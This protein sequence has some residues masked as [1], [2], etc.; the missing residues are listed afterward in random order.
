MSPTQL[1]MTT[2]GRVCARCARIVRIESPFTMVLAMC[3]SH[4]VP[5]RR[6]QSAPLS[7]R[8]PYVGPGH[9]GPAVD[10]RGPRKKKCDENRP[11]CSD[12]R[13]LNLPCQWFSTTS[14]AETI[15]TS[16]SSSPDSHATVSPSAD[17][18]LPSD[19]DPLALS[20]ITPEDDEEFIATLFP[21][22]LP[23]QT[24]LVL[25]LEW[26]PISTNPFLRG[27]EDRSLFNH[28]IHV[29][30]RALSRS[31]DPDR[32]PFLVTLLPLA[33][34]SDAV[35]SVILSLSGCHW[36]RVYPS[37]WG[38]A[39]KRQ[40]Q[41]CLLGRSDRQCIF[42]ACATVLLLCLTELFD[43]T[44]KVWKWH[45][46][47]AS[48]ILKSPAFQN[49]VS[50]DE[51]TFC[52]SLFHY[53]DAMSTISRCKA[54]LLHNSDNLAELTTSL[55]RNS[56]PELERSQST[57]AIYG[58]SP[59]LFDFLGMVNLLANHRS[60]RVDELSEIGFRTAASHL[61]TRIDEW[62]TDHDQ[63]TELEPET[64][65]A[66]TA[67]EWAIRLR[68]HQVVEGYDPLHPFVERSITIIL[69]AVQ[70]VP[71][72]SRV[73]GC[74]LFPLVIAGS[75]SISMERRMMVKERL[76]VMENTLGFGHIQYARQLLETVW[77]GASC[78]TDLN[79]AAVRYSKFPG[80]VF[81]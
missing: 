26:S 27:E 61:E 38:C 77:N 23:K 6:S 16:S 20:S 25:P 64:E 69:D 30:A 48:A 32:N 39:L 31:H 55:R 1:A 44:S 59:A 15:D 73:E 21:H 19:G 42:E 49:L 67:F 18:I 80:V 8:R 51:W 22:P 81:V 52:I 10:S 58:I 41:G 47:A 13:R 50:T 57:D 43:G 70:Q 24:A 71:Y 68:L 7:P 66:T 28:Y 53:L 65:R 40:G 35:T 37:I 45:L 3:A 63:I 4:E 36:R 54:P 46:K 12:C 72:A 78:A 34:A 2:P 5:L 17:P 60:K 62:R 33:A 9:R 14:T 56:V 74:L 79:W 75:S 11:R 76:M 29:V